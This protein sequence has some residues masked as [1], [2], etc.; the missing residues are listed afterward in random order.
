M[1]S[2]FFDSE[3][4][5]GVIVDFDREV[6]VALSEKRKRVD[7]KVL[8]EDGS[9]SDLAWI[10]LKHW[11]SE[12]KGTRYPPRFYFGDSSSVGIRPDIDALRSIDSGAKFCLI[13]MTV[14]PGNVDWDAGI[15]HFNEKYA[16]LH[17]SGLNSP[18]DFPNSYH[19]GLLK[20]DT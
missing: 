8:F 10:E 14:N 5:R 16:P 4:H 6:R 17:I 2:F 7:L 9:D 15:Q 12:Q 13:L 3:K 20:V 19:L 1:S 11:V 18:S